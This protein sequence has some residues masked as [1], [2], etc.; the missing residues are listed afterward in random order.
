MPIGITCEIQAQTDLLSNWTTSSH[1]YFEKNSLDSNEWLSINDFG[2]LGGENSVTI[3]TASTADG[4]TDGGNDDP[5][6]TPPDSVSVDAPTPL[7]MLLGALLFSANF[8][9]LRTT[10]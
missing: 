8:F 2:V 6:D 4:D 9:R 3:V 1:T 5:V 7:F 10:L